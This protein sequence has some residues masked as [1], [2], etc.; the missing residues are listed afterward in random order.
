MPTI[1]PLSQPVFRVAGALIALTMSGCDLSKTTPPANPRASSYRTAAASSDSSPQYYLVFDRQELVSPLGAEVVV[2]ARAP[3]SEANIRSVISRNGAAASRLTA[4]D[5]VRN[6]WLVELSS[7]PS[8]GTEALAQS[9]R[10]DPDLIFAEPVYAHVGSGSQ[11]RLVNRLV[12]R[13][14]PNIAQAAVD[15]FASNLQVT[16]ERSPRPDSGFFEHLYSYPEGSDSRALTIAA[17]AAKHPAVA[18]AAPD[19]VS[20]VRPAYVP[21]DPYYSLQLHLKNT[22]YYNGV[23]VDDNVEQAWDLTIGSGI[24]VAVVDDGVD[25]THPDYA[26]SFSGAQ[27]YDLMYGTACQGDSFHPHESTRVFRRARYVSAPTSTGVV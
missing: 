23:R 27:G 13:F 7:S 8:R 19:F 26:T 18:W 9:L 14:L 16:L 4:I 10:Q 1:N 20:D 12:V 25:F 17:R 2:Q 21:T 5:V 24:K 6:H 22:A 15:S 11:V 3:L